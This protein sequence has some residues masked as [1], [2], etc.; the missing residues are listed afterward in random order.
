MAAAAAASEP[1]ADDLIL[2]ILACASTDIV[3]LFRCAVTC[4][5]WRDLVADLP[6]LHRHWP[7]RER[8]RSALLGFFVQQQQ[9]PKNIKPLEP[10]F[11]PPLSGS[12]F[13][14]HRR[15]LASFIPGFPCGELDGAMPLT[16]RHGLLLV[17]LARRDDDDPTRLAVCNLL[18][19]T[20]EVLPTLKRGVF[21]VHCAIITDADCRSSDRHHQRSPFF[22]VLANIVADDYRNDYREYNNLYI[23][24]SAKHGWSDPTNWFHRWFN[25]DNPVSLQWRKRVVVCG[26]MAHWLVASVSRFYILGVSIQTDDICLKELLIPT[27]I[28]QSWCSWSKYV[29]R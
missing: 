14:S 11:L 26:A 10:A 1:L 12:V 27:E 25:E 20:C 7:E 8:H 24:S 3:T 17:Q 13:G 18:A 2:E 22:K 21:S 19:G 6:F 23:Y 5:R 16:A 28:A 29:G 4:K 9:Y 15:S